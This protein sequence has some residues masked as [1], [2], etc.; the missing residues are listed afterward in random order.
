MLVI[1]TCVPSL[2]VPCRATELELPQGWEEAAVL[3][4]AEKEFP[5]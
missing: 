1:G 5:S 2:A 3:K 4:M